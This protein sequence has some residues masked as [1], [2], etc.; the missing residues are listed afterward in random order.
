MTKVFK[1]KG[2]VFPFGFG[3]ALPAASWAWVLKY[4]MTRGYFEGLEDFVQD[5]SV[6]GSFNFLVGFLVVFRTSQSYNRF[7]DGCTATHKMRAEWFDACSALISFCRHSEESYVKINRFQRLLV[8]LFSM[9]HAVAL[10]E[11]E[12]CNSEVLDDIMA[13]KFEVLDC[14]VFD[15]ESLKAVRDSDCKTELVFQWIQMA[16]VD[17]IKTG[18]LSIPPPI[19]SRA[20]QE[21]ANGMVAAHDAIK[22]SCIPFPFPYAQT[23]DLLLIMHWILCPLVVAPW[24]TSEWWSFSFC[25]AQVFC[26]W[27]MNRIAVEIENPFGADSNDLDGEDMQMEMNRHLSLLLSPSTKKTPHLVFREG[28]RET[29]Y[30]G[31]YSLMAAWEHVEEGS[32]P[33]EMRDLTY[34]ATADSSHY[35]TSQPRDTTSSTMTGARIS[36]YSNNDMGASTSTRTGTASIGQ[37]T[38]TEPAS[39]HAG[40][41]KI[42]RGPTWNRISVESIS[43]PVIG[44]NG[45]PHK[46][47]GTGLSKKPRVARSVR[48]YGNRKRTHEFSAD[49][50]RNML[51]SIARSE[52][53]DSIQLQRASL[54]SDYT[55]TT[56][57]SMPEAKPRVEKSIRSEADG[58]QELNS[59]RLSGSDELK[60]SSG[61][62][63]EYEFCSLAPHDRKLS[64]ITDSRLVAAD[65]LISGVSFS[66]RSSLGRHSNPRGSNQRAS[67]ASQAAAFEAITEDGDHDPEE[68]HQQQGGSTGSRSR[69]AIGR[70]IVP[71]ISRSTIIS[72]SGGAGG[73]C[74][75]VK[76]DILPEGDFHR[77]VSQSGSD[78]PSER[79]VHFE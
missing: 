53:E 56:V 73:A 12:D 17:N 58:E 35:A 41:P 32:E 2:S 49:F 27:T 33:G 63:Q 66:E 26:M 19:L 9:L 31:W 70:G 16:I 34:D 59:L 46:N 75:P 48:N 28:S 67:V 43:T 50:Q 77:T 57:G 68:V 39:V 37:G 52:E 23:C 76:E 38:H 14:K 22:I 47:D 8:H 5:N 4:L 29:H 62:H 78:H 40:R 21:L 36:S 3:V 13:Y 69:E 1:I 55:R 7:W 72:A 11:I 10:A 30:S 45:E 74:E 71:R 64:S 51:Q 54:S 79:G 25:F 61:I 20:F 42:Q 44:Y 15:D 65:S 60:G 24:V 6:W 18:V